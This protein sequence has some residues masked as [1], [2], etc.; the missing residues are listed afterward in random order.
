[1]PQSKTKKFSKNILK[2]SVVLY[3]VFVAAL[4][5]LLVFGYQRD[6][7][8]GAIFVLVAFLTTFFSKNMIVILCLAMVVANIY[9]YG[10]E[11]AVSEGTKE[12]FTEAVDTNAHNDTNMDTHINND[13]QSEPLDS[14]SHLDQKKE[15]PEKKEKHESLQ[16]ITPELKAK[17]KKTFNEKVN[18][19][20][21]SKE[22]KDKMTKQYDAM[23]TM[24]EQ[25]SNMQPAIEQFKAEM[26][27]LSP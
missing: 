23:L 21:H 19:S 14:V 17:L 18:N 11:V 8:S 27:S 20:N 26:S 22:K 12:G 24:A 4:I 15:K 1:M 25:F 2:N 6:W 10:S 5:N 13:N 7:M 9:K 3:L 16:K